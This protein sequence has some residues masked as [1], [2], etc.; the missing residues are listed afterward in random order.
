[1]SRIKDWP[2]V[3]G[4]RHGRL[5][6]VELIGRNKHGHMCVRCKC[7]C[8][9]FT[10]KEA[11]AVCNEVILS[12]GCLQREASA[13]IFKTHGMTGT[14]IHN[15]WLSMISRCENE[16]NNRFYV[17]G[18]RGIKVCN[19]W[20]T[21]FQNFYDWAIANG[22]SDDLTI[23]RIDIDGNYC[24]ENCRWATRKEQ[25]NNKS[26]NHLLEYKGKV[27]NIKEWSEYFGFNYKYFHE[28]LKKNNWSIQKV[29]EIPYFKERMKCG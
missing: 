21:D 1:M 8:G 24:P 26:T 29:L 19:E 13:K 17:Y 12:C 18:G 14:R 28:K 5:Q 9:N 6:I 27:K 16:K 20:R 25:A 11:T 4:E 23:D 22:Y 10:T 15:I 3:V 7:D 2:S